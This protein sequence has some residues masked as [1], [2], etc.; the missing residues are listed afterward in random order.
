M[1]WFSLAE[2]SYAQGLPFK[3]FLICSAGFFL[4]SCVNYTVPYYLIW[5]YN[6]LTG[7]IENSVGSELL[8]FRE[9]LL[10]LIPPHSSQNLPSFC[11]M[12]VITKL[13]SF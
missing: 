6:L 10:S 7:V 1:S 4:Y 9:P 5:E 2:V 12:V 8:G 13:F 3:M 11:D